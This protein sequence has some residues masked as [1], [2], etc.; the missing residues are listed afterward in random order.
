MDQEEKNHDIFRL[1]FTDKG[2]VRKEAK[3]KELARPGHC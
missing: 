1:I 3:C 2:A